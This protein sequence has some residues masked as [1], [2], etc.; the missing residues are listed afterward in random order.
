MILFAVLLLW[1]LAYAGI[2]STNGVYE[3][4]ALFPSADPNVTTTPGPY[5]G[6]ED[7][8]YNTLQNRAFQ[9]SNVL[10]PPGIDFGVYPPTNT[11]LAAPNTTAPNTT[12][13]PVAGS[14]DSTTTGAPFATGAAPPTRRPRPTHVTPTPRAMMPTTRAPV[15]RRPMRNVAAAP[16]PPRG[17]GP[18][19]GMP[20]HHGMTTR[21]VMGM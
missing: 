12:T 5:V 15:T 16:P 14:F 6:Y 4:F 11:S 17:M 7:S 1:C 19:R 3:G 18:A 20:A 2:C 8:D 13:A 10:R 9:N 21:G